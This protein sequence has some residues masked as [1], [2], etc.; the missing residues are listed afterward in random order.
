MFYYDGLEPIHNKKDNIR[1]PLVCVNPISLNFSNRY[2]KYR[3]TYRVIGTDL[4]M[5]LVVR[6]KAFLL[7]TFVFGGTLASM[8]QVLT[9]LLKVDDNT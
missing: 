9:G 3:S 2:I 5:H 6:L 1:S 4:V 8:I 7:F